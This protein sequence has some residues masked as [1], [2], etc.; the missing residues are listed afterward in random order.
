MGKSQRL[1]MAREAVR[2]AKL[3]KESGKD[4]D[5]DVTP[6]QLL[7]TIQNNLNT[8]EEKVREVHKKFA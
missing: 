1:N 4:G 6:E 3:A 2:L 8:F 5:R 7:E